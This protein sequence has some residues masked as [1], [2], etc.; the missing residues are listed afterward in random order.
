MSSYQNLLRYVPQQISFPFAFHTSTNLCTQSLLY[1]TLTSRN[2]PASHHKKGWCW[3]DRSGPSKNVNNVC[4]RS[5]AGSVMMSTHGRPQRATIWHLLAIMT[6]KKLQLTHQPRRKSLNQL[7]FH[8]KSIRSFI[9]SG[10]GLSTIFHSKLSVL[11]A[12]KNRVEKGKETLEKLF[13]YYKITVQYQIW[14]SSKSK[15]WYQFSL[16][17]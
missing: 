6:T 8:K 16:A 12:E 17:P 10:I 9:F 15:I 13:T 2:D 14:I 7:F 11:K 4:S 3:K 5:Y 1:S